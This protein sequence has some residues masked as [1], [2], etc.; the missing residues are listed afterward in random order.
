LYFKVDPLD[1]D[2]LR[3]QSLYKLTKLIFVIK[4]KTKYFVIYFLTFNEK[5]NK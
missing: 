4:Q 3:R 5:N 2:Y 1:A